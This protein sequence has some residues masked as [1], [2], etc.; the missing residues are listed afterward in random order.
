MIFWEKCTFYLCKLILNP[1]DNA[2]SGE[3]LFLLLFTDYA[4]YRKPNLVF[5]CQKAHNVVTY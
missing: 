3:D 5:R 4:I 1:P 2:R